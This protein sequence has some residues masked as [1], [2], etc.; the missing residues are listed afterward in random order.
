MLG[1]VWDPNFDELTSGLRTIP[2]ST[3]SGHEMALDLQKRPAHHGHGRGHTYNATENSRV[4]LLAGP[5]KMGRLPT[6]H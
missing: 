5:I 6:I 2:V 4:V 3:R 1:D